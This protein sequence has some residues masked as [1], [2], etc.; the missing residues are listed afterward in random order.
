MRFIDLSTVIARS[1][2]RF[3]DL[4]GNIDFRTILPSYRGQCVGELL[5]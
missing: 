3:I 1:Y 4:S 2:M 5:N